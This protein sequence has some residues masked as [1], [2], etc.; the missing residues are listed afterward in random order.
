M[1]STTRRRN[2]Y[3]HRLCD[4][5]RS[6]GNIDHATRRGIPR[7]T[8][9]GWLNRRHC[10]L[11]TLD[12]VDQDRLQLQQQVLALRRRTERLQAL[13]R[14]MV[15]LWKI[16]GCALN[17][18]RIPGSAG[19]LRLMAAI[20][21]C[22]SVLPLR[23][24]LRIIGLSQSSYHA[25]RRDRPCALAEV[26]ACPHSAPQ[27]LT[28]VELAALK[29]MVTSQEYRHVPTG[30]LALLAQRLGKVFASRTTWYR[31]V[32]RFQ[33]RRP[34]KRLHPS[35]PKIGIRAGRA[36]EIWHVDTTLLRLLDGSRAY[37]HAIIDNF[38]RRILAWKVAARFDVTATAEL[39]VHA[40]APLN[41]QQPTLLADAGVE[42]F[43]SAVDRLVQSGVL[44]RLL[45]QT[46]IA[47]SNSL[48]ESWWRT[49]KHQWLYLNSLDTIATLKKL[50]DFYVKEH[51][52]RL[53][54]SAFR[55]QTPDEVY[56]GTGRQ[57]PEQL[58]AARLAARHARRM[59]NRT[60]SCQH[61]DP[62]TVLSN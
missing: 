16:S 14:V 48:I 57:V 37:L 22:R 19:K 34:R 44:K 43:N 51:N 17:D 55:G 21:Q 24:V 35:Q 32:R 62:M 36:N 28:P 11:V 39:L 1:D 47:F 12:V 50:V 18:N 2:R 20:G 46:E 7:S 3:D 9:R 26:S 15:V 29:D 13:L 45:A 49:L 38:S 56:F 31:L 60:M 33:W 23:V 25:W 27:Q 5:V 61:C 8:A 6:T 54:H 53:P 40:A 30:T 52:A 59:I 42:N 4:L 41:D 10:G 58:E